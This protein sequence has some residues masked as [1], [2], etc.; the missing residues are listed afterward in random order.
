MALLATLKKFMG[1]AAALLDDST[2]LP[3]GTRLYDILKSLAQ[4]GMRVIDGYQQT[5]AVLGFATTLLDKDVKLT[6]FRM[7]VD[8]TGTAGAT[9]CRVHR[10]GV[11]IPGAEITID[12]SDPDGT[13]KSVALDVDLE[14]G[15]LIVIYT[16]AT[17]TGGNDIF[18]SAYMSSVVVE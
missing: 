17:P 15:D 12:S 2:G 1:N 8:T 9:T 13:Q 4:S 3:S 7:K 11:D 10:N 16:V 5:P 14:A 18:V 6:K